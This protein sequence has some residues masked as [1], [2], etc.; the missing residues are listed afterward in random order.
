MVRKH[1]PL[2]NQT[3]VKRESVLNKSVARKEYTLVLNVRIG[4]KE[5][6]CRAE[7]SYLY[8]VGGDKN[9]RSLHSTTPNQKRNTNTSGTNMSLIADISSARS[10]LHYDDLL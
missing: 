7:R 8:N 5:Y 4:R 9:F 3:D 10:S 6:L 1:S 2:H